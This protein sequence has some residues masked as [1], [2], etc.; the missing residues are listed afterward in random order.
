MI[1]IPRCFSCRHFIMDY[2][3]K[4]VYKCKAYPDG[5]PDDKFL[6]SS[7][8]EDEC[9]LKYHYEREGENP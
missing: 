5:I 7:L 3:E 9:T 1:K 6:E 2:S 8:S 4:G